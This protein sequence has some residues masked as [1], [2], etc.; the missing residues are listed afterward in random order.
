MLLLPKYWERS[1]RWLA[2][3]F[4]TT[5]ISIGRWRADQGATIVAPL[6]ELNLSDARLEE[7]HTLILKAERISKDGQVRDAVMRRHRI[8]RVTLWGEFGNGIAGDLVMDELNR[9]CKTLNSA[10]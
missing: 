5:D 4:R 1:D 6:N 9:T 3:D 8:A 10:M 7:L 2:E